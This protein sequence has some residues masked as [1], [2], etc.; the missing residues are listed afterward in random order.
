L[1]QLVPD[2]SLSYLSY[3]HKV[4][5][6]NSVGLSMRYFNY[7]SIQFRDN[8]QT[9]LGTYSPNEFSLNGAFARKFGNDLSLGLTIGYIHSNLSNAFFASGTGQAAQSGNAIAA[10][11]SLF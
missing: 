6:R 1:R 5:E 9:D 7:G 8:N 10:G 11:V 2:I 4:D 3:A